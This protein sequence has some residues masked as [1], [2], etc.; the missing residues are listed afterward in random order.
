MTDSSSHNSEEGGSAP[1]TAGNGKWGN[2]GE[3]SARDIQGLQFRSFNEAEE[4]YREYAKHHGFV[5]RK[6]EARKNKDNEVVSKVFVCNRAGHRNPK[7][8]NRS[9][10]KKDPRPITRIGCPAYLHIRYNLRKSRWFVD[11]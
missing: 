9:D 11:G 10:R 8:L 5:V 7:H 1:E 2:I 6:D 4:F 3:L